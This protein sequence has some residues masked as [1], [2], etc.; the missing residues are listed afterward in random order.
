MPLSVAE[1]QPVL[2]DL[3]HDTAD[4]LAKETGFCLRKRKLSGGVFAKTVTF[5]LLENPDATLDDFADFALAELHVDV[6]AQAF[7][8]RFG[9]PAADFLSALLADALGRR[10]GTL[11]PSLLPVLRRFEGVY[12]RDAT[13]VSLPSRLAGAFPARASGDGKPAAAVKLVWE[14]ELTTGQFTEVEFTDAT[15]NE[16]TSEVADK[17]LPRGSLLLEDMGFL[18]GQRLRGYIADGVYFLTRVPSWTAFFVPEGRRYRRF[19]PVKKLRH[20]KG[21]WVHLKVCVFHDGK[22]PLRL[23]AVRVPEKVARERRDRV[24]ADAKKRGRPVSERKLE[25]C[26]WNILVTNAPEELIGVSEGWE[27]RAVRWQIELAFKLFKSEGGLERTRSS[28]RW[29]VLAELC[30]KLLGQVVQRWV[31]SAGGYASLMHSARRAARRVRKRAGALARALSD[32]AS[33]AAEVLTLAVM[34]RRRCRIERRR[35]HPATLD[36]LADMDAEYRELESAQR[37]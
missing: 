12:A 5:C 30:A 7:D 8:G 27:L 29:R 18:C 6:S 4:D 28:D 24:R 19:D 20:A 22:L 33:L 11:R 15:R 9:E 21:D 13:L 35:K 31:L 14:L 26:D 17:P 37:P 25:L 34:L 3:F 2:H 10:F 36:R 16:K 1:L 32:L 23:L